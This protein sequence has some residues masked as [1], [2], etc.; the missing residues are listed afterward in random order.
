[1]NYIIASIEGPR[2]DIAPKYK[3]KHGKIYKYGTFSLLIWVGGEYEH[4]EYEE[5]Y[6]EVSDYVTKVNDELK[7]DMYHRG[8]CYA[9]MLT[10]REQHQYNDI[11]CEEFHSWLI[12]KILNADLLI[13]SKVNV[14]GKDLH[15]RIDVWKNME[16]VGKMLRVV[17]REMLK[18]I[19]EPG[20]YSHNCY[21]KNS[22]LFLKGYPIFELGWTLPYSIQIVD[23]SY[24]PGFKE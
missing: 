15:D 12:N 17:S 20:S 19:H 1:M 18:Y 16:E 22:D 2:F 3:G 4:R 14:C 13:V 23:K 9:Q 8:W 6:R 5:A 10:P 24:Y 21:V 7:G 11:R